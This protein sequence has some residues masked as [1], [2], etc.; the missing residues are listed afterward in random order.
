MNEDVD[1]CDEFVKACGIVIQLWELIVLEY[2]YYWK[3]LEI[4][5]KQ[6]MIC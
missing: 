6:F 2:N 1:K 5:I 4:P 3:T